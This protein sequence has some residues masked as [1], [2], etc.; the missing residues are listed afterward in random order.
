MWHGTWLLGALKNR[1]PTFV[2]DIFIHSENERIL[3][4]NPNAPDWITIKQKYK[5]IFDLING[6]NSKKAIYDFIT[7]NYTDEKEILISQMKNHFQTLNIFKHSYR[8]PLFHNKKTRLPQ[9]IYLTLTD[10]CNLHCVYCYATERTKNE[11]I[12]LDKWVEYVTSII[13]FAGKPTFVFTGGEPLTVPYVFELAS[14]I[15]NRGCEL[16][17]LTNGTLITS[18]NIAS[19]IASLF[20]L[21]KI[22]LDSIDD[23][24]NT[25]LR[26]NNVLKKVKYAYDMLIDKKCNVRILATVTSNTCNDLNVFSEYFNNNVNFQPFYS[27]GRARNEDDLYISGE[28]YY[29]ALTKSGKFVFLKDFHNRIFTFKNNP[30]KKCSMAEVELSICSNGDIFPCHML[31]YNE[32]FC[33]NLNENS[34]KNIFYNSQVLNDLRKINVD[35]IPQCIKCVYRNICGGACRARVNI[36]KDGILGND[37]FCVFEQKQILDALM[38]SYG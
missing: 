1:K 33:G 25:E 35:S 27:M 2:D 6:K 37:N 32:Y 29:E 24:I 17:L 3:Y 30:C 15:K 12:S 20:S 7:V 14:F 31:H 9:N 10:N 19:N 11:D 21:V 36:S 16:V 8:T 5:P 23:R 28:Q 22:S 4:L 34:I 26:G 18:E 13:S 38:Y